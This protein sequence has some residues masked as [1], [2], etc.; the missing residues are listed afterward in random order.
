MREKPVFIFDMDGTLLD[1]NR[2]WCE[3]GSRYLISKGVTPP[4]NAAELAQTMR[5]T[6]FIRYML[7]TYRIDETVEQVRDWIFSDIAAQY[8]NAVCKRDTAAFLE[9]ARKLG[10]RMCVATATDHALAD[11]VLKRLGLW[12]YFDFVYDCAQFQTSKSQP[13]L[14]LNC[15]KRF[16]VEPEQAVVFEDASYSMESAKKA[17]FYTVGIQDDTELYEEKLKM[18]SDQFIVRYAE[19]DVT[20]LPGWENRA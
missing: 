20:K 13:T 18:L 11:P 12:D 1:T 6:A 14:F 9:K 19:L 8:Q 16:G 15:C 4:E 2:M 5:F 7:E 3:Y 10:I 17:G